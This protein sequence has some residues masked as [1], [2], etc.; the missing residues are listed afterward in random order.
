M[1]QTPDV[2][3]KELI[4]A[5]VADLQRLV[6]AQVALAKLEILNTT[7]T[8]AK[9]SGLLIG[10]L[11]IAGLGFIFLLV[12]LAYVLVALGL[13]VW[14]GFGIVTLLLM[15]S[16]AILGLLGKKEAEKIKGPEKTIEEIDKTKVALTEAVGGQQAVAALQMYEDTRAAIKDQ[17][18]DLVVGEV[19]I[20][21]TP[22]PGS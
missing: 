17:A 15:I 20:E 21:P 2:S 18:L 8:A 6:K 9:T 3:I 19:I 5:A 7:K 1:A 4:S 12:T 22:K 14:A 16:A 10:A 13:P 11:M